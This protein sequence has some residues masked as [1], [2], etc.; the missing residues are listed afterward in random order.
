MR[1]HA[2]WALGCLQA[3]SSA[4]AIG[5]HSTRTEM[6]SSFPGMTER[7]ITITIRGL[8]AAPDSGLSGPTTPAERVALV[9]TLT[10]EA[11][12]LAGGDPP[13]YARH[14]APVSVRPLRVSGQW[15]R[16]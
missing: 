16:H 15:V 5:H 13:A 12:A 3:S 8:R 14:E 7:P 6:G 4:G 2:A 10:R 11:W 9:E 1:E